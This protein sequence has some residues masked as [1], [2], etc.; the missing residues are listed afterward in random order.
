MTEVITF[1][2]ASG[3]LA[4]L[5]AGAIVLAMFILE[6][7]ALCVGFSLHSFNIDADADID[8]DGVLGWLNP[9]KVPVVLLLTAFLGLFSIA[10]F[11][12]NWIWTGMG[13]KMLTPLFVSPLVAVMVLP[14]VSKLS[15]TLGHLLHQEDSNAVMLDDLLGY[16]GVCT[17]G[18][19]Q[20]LV[21]G[22][23]RFKDDYG[24]SHYLDVVAEPGKT[25]EM[26]DDVVLLQRF[27]EGSFMFVIRKAN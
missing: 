4:F 26:G 6:L 12:T 18:P 8:V 24:V 10:G 20:E 3:N 1:L 21:A 2:F 27:A 7:L 16:Y 14:L 25:I 9:G 22:Q 5:T 15:Y 17:L 11:I 13:F 19:V 23:A